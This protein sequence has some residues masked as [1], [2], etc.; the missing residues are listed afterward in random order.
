M[1]Y[2]KLISFGNSSYIISLPKAWVD[3]HKL[4][5]GDL[6]YIDEKQDE[7]SVFP[8]NHEVKEEPKEI[9]IDIT[10]KTDDAIRREITA[11]YSNNYGTITVIG[12]QLQSKADDIREYLHELVALEIMQQTSQKIVAKCFLNAKELSF[13]DMIRRMDIIIRAMFEDLAKNDGKEIDFKEI[14][15]RDTDV[16]R[17]FYIAQRVVRTAMKD[18]HLAKSLNLSL[19]QLMSDD[20]NIVNLEHIADEL[21]RIARILSTEDLKKA[22]NAEFLQILSNTA[23]IYN[24]VMKAYYLRNLKLSEEVAEASKVLLIESESLLKKT[25]RPTLA[26]LVEKLK[27]LQNH[28]RYIAR[29]VILD[30]I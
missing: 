20:K 15:A 16:N 2:R 10:S 18:P 7:L 4:V 23:K 17:L 19:H 21:K 28:I 1:E 27:S 13:N 12:E 25:V 30:N 9:T 11:A 14:Q 6:V 22:E 24:N 26:S 8:G 29:N 5:K 3:K